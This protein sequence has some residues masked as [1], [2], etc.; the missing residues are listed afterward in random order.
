M[1]NQES[2]QERY[3][4]KKKHAS[5]ALTRNETFGKNKASTSEIKIRSLFLFSSPPT[6]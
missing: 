3:R 5:V 4:R 1:F 6:R 2:N